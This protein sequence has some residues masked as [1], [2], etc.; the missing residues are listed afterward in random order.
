MTSHPR[1]A[2]VP[3]PPAG[4]AGRVVATPPVD[5]AF[6]AGPAVTAPP[7]DRALAAAL[8]VAV[9][10]GVAWIAGMIHTVTGWSV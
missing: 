8:V 9:I 4:R 1:P 2:T 10:A 6:T 7:V 5:R 3:T